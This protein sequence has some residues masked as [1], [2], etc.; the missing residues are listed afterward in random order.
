MSEIYWFLN[1]YSESKKLDSIIEK[2]I[3]FKEVVD[4]FEVTGDY[5][6]VALV[7]AK[8]PLE[9]RRFLKDKILRIDGVRGTNST[10]I[11][12]VNKRDG[13]VLEG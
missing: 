10:L 1:I 3:N 11:L 4:L 12:Y 7:K 5:D 8:T 6:I 13:K 9:F 2:L